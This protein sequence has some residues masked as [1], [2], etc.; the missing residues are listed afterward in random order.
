MFIRMFLYAKSKKETISICSNILSN[1]DIHIEKRKV[2]EIVPYWK[3]EGVFQIELSIAL[4]N[5]SIDSNDWERFLKTLSNI[6]LS[7][8]E[9]IDEILITRKLDGSIIDNEKIEMINIF[10]DNEKIIAK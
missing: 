8:G 2:V 1:I 10:L 3:I 6:W 4:K 7:Y 9:P 5:N